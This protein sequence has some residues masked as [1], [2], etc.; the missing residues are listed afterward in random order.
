MWVDLKLQLFD[1]GDHQFCTKVA[2]HNSNK[3][4]NILQEIEHEAPYKPFTGKKNIMV[5]SQDWWIFVE[6]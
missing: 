2:M 4:S 1:T 5:A 3:S 6:L